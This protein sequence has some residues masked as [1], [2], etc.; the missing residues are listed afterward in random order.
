MT[1]YCLTVHPHWAWAIIHGRKRIENRTWTTNH[2]GRLFIHASS[3]RVPID[4]CHLSLLKGMPSPDD[5]TIGAIIGFVDVV[6]C[7]P[8]GEV[9]EDPYA[10]GPW[11][12][13]LRKPTPIQPVQCLGRTKLW[14]PPRRAVSAARHTRSPR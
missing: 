8:W 5:L 13:T 1:E 11:C 2:R 14:H 6:D 10:F 12:W 9:K 3:R 4:P 7:V